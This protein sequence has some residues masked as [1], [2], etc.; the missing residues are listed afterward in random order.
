LLYSLYQ[1]I[2]A[3]SRM[4]RLLTTLVLIV[5][6]I[7]LPSSA[8]SEEKAYQTG[9]VV[10]IVKKARERVLYYQGNNPIT[11]DDPYY[12]VSVR[13]KDTIYVGEYDPPQFGFDPIPNEWR[14]DQSVQIKP[15]KHRFHAVPPHGH[16]LDFVLIKKKPAETMP[17]T[18]NPAP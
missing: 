15:E 12:E 7:I 11:R 10:G 2:L 16:E 8:F 5:I 1:P 18:P 9:Q 4:K 13:V 14:I 17:S 6:I 3:G